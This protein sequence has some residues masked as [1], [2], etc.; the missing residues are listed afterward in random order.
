MVIVVSKLYN[1]SVCRHAKSF[2]LKFF[3]KKLLESLILLDD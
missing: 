3:W 2:D 1:P